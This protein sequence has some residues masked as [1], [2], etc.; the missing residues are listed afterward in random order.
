MEIRKIKNEDYEMITD[1]T[2]E[3][4]TN[5]EHGYG[6]EA[7]LVKNIR[8]LDSYDDNLELVATENN[9][10]I[11]H[12]LLSEVKIKEN[13]LSGL[14]LA[15]ISVSTERQ[16]QKIGSQL[17]QEIE[18][19]A[20]QTNFNF[21]VILGDPNFY[22][23]FGYKEAQTFNIKAPFEVP[24]EF[25]LIKMIKDNNSTNYA[26]TIEYNSAFN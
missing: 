4:F 11:G 26:G 8:K 2:I 3:A 17:M 10:I 6:G 25:Y 24:K 14:A 20:V 22:K 18:K 12:A 19:K 15:P 1:L 5:S 16:N 21:I 7:D 23:R 9:Q 13:N